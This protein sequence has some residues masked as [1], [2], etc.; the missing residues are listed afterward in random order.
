MLFGGIFLGLL[1]GLAAGGRLDNLL[2]VRLR[3]PLLLFGAV[4]VRLGTEAALGHGIALAETLRLPLLLAAYAVLAVALWANRARP[5]MS[6]ALVGI[7]FN[8]AAMAANGGFMP[9]WEPSLAAAGFAPAEALSPIHVLLPPILD[10]SFLAHAGPLGDVVPIPIPFARNVTSIGDVFLA[11]GL[12]FFLFASVLRRPEEVGGPE[13]D[14]AAREGRLSG[15]AA[16]ARLRGASPGWSS[17]RRSARRRAWPRRSRRRRRSIDR[18]SS[19]DPGRDWW[20]QLSP[21]S[22]STTRA[23]RRRARWRPWHRRGPRSSGERSGRRCGSAC[24][25]TRMSGSR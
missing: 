6:L 22:R 15:L 14:R 10:A 17:A 12:A 13:L 23:S 24:A 9:I 18:W 19:A 25:A 5:G 8:A 7:A 2:A 11:L 16:A 1:P 3:W 21:R 4:A 20:C